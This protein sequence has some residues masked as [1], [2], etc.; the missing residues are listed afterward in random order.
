[1]AREI[2]RQNGWGRNGLFLGIGANLCRHGIWN[3][4][5]FGIYHNLRFF[6]TH[7]QIYSFYV[8]TLICPEH[9]PK[10]G[11]NEGRLPIR[12]TIASLSAIIANLANIPF[13]VAKSRIQGPQP[14]NGRIYYSTW[15]TI[16]L[17]QRQHGFSTI[18]R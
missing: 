9:R 11:Q 6:P 14:K 5:Y 13:D 1:M 3:C 8:R 7:I 2:L 16:S 18:Y 15:Q 17:V 10:E 4:C 12:L